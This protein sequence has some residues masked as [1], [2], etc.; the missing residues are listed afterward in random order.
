MDGYEIYEVKYLLEP[1]QESLIEKEKEKILHLSGLNVKQ[2]GF[3]S[4]SGFEHEGERRISG[5]DIYAL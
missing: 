3:V 1:M 5:E 4:S 2:I